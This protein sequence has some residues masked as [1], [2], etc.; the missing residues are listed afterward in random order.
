MAGVPAGGSTLK[1]ILIGVFTT[2]AAYM[3]VHF[4]T[5]K[6]QKRKEKEKIKTATVE[7]WKSLLKYEEISTANYYAG[8]CIEDVPSQLEALIYEKD[9]LAKNY[10]LISNK[11]GIDDDL[12][13]FANRAVGNTNEIKK[14]LENYLADFQKINPADPAATYLYQQTDSIFTHKI[15]MARERDQEALE[16][17]YKNL[18]EKYGDDFTVTEHPDKLSREALYGK[19]KETG[20]DK[21]FHFKA[22]DVFVMTADGN[23]YTGT[24]KLD[25]RVAT[26]TYD[27][28]SGSITLHISRFHDKFMLYSINNEAA[29]R[30]ACRQ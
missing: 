13:S 17:I 3:I 20:I 5:D 29:E 1:T 15:Q 24:W 7:A 6:K 22:G 11:Q 16:S 19:W 18:L 30:H 26:L 10:A 25:G 23:D 14:L 28:G 4:V 9:Q 12:A 21:T 2:V 27:D 8:M